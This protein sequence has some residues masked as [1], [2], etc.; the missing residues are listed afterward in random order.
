MVD[1]AVRQ[2]I[3]K[4]APTDVFMSANTKDVDMLKN[5]IKLIIHINTHI[6]SWY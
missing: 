6:I 2:Q 1:R 4:G 5:I 3:E